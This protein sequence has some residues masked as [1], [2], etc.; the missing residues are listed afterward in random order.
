MYDSA[1]QFYDRVS[2]AEDNGPTPL[3]R[4]QDEQPQA[5]NAIDKT[6]A[7]GTYDIIANYTKWSTNAKDRIGMQYIDDIDRQEIQR[8]MMN[9]TPVKKKDNRHL[10]DNVDNYDKDRVMLNKSFNER[11]GL[12]HT[13][14]L[15]AQQVLDI[16]KPN[17][18]RTHVP[19]Y[20]TQVQIGENA[21]DIERNMGLDAMIPQVDGP[22]DTSNS[23]S[24][25]TD[26]IDLTVFPP[27]KGIPNTDRQ[28]INKDTS[29]DNIDQTYYENRIQTRASTKSKGIRKS[30]V[31]AQLNKA[32][33][34]QAKATQAKV[35]T[36]R[37][38]DH[39]KYHKS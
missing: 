16:V 21:R 28:N 24:I 27:K 31:R 18:Q 1:K 11:I 13:S 25:T 14:L 9:D 38:P 34:T 10:V 17:D 3:Q 22:V 8:L 23:S 37:R 29:N 20:L 7:Q 6:I 15:G 12:G 35:T 30:T 4:Q 19:N 5:V 26:S 2:G 32:K 36:K 39:N 33:A